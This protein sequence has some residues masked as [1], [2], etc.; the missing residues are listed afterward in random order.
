MTPCQDTEFSSPQSLFSKEYKITNK[1][2]NT[3]EQPSPSQKST[4]NSLKVFT[5]LKL[6]CWFFFKAQWFIY[7]ARK[8][9]WKALFVYI[10]L[11]MRC[12]RRKEKTFWYWYP[13]HSG[14]QIERRCKIIS[15]IKNEIILLFWRWHGVGLSVTVAAV[16]YDWYLYAHIF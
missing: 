2:Q 5:T 16:R 7:T 15:N 10:M 13:P 4:K 14:M 11:W 9:S 12:N 8:S 1:E 3:T 6:L